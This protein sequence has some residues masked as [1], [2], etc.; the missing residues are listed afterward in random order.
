MSVEVDKPGNEVLA[1]GLDDGPR[2][3]GLDDR[4]DGRDEAVAHGQVV[5]AGD[6]RA[7]VENV[8][9]PN[10]QVVGAHDRAG[11]VSVATARTRHPRTG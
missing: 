4:L 5:P 1:A 3:P 9:A 10:Q 2:Q 7:G 11:I 6:S 8:G